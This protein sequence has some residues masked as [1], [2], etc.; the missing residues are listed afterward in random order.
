MP[1][2]ANHSAREFVTECLPFRG[3]NTYGRTLFDGSYAAFS[4]GEHW[5]LYLWWRGG[6][7]WFANT[8]S[9]S[10]TT[11]KHA[12]QLRPRDA[13]CVPLPTT[14][15]LALVQFCDGDIQRQANWSRQVDVFEEARVAQAAARVERAT[16]VVAAKA[17]IIAPPGKRRLLPLTS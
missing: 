4:Y 13:N 3:N 10:R 1:R 5:P 2:V 15:L 14:V 17:A 8:G 9:Y 7:Q 6:G 16:A 11:S 12:G